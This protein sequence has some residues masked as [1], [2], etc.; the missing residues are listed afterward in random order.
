[1]VDITAILAINRYHTFIMHDGKVYVNLCLETELKGIISYDTSP[2]C[3]SNF[4][5][6]Y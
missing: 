1:M 3:T 2:T 4:N 5:I 6:N